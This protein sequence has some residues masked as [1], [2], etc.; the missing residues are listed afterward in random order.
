MT[1]PRVDRPNRKPQGD[2]VARTVR[3]PPQLWADLKAT[4]DGVR[5]CNINHSVVLAVYRLLIDQP[6]HALPR[7]NW[8]DSRN[9]LNHK[10]SKNSRSSVSTFVANEDAPRVEGSVLP[11]A[12]GESEPTREP[13][14]EIADLPKT[15]FKY[16]AALS[17]EE[18]R[19]NEM[20]SGRHGG[21]PPS[22]A[23][24]WKEDPV[25]M[26]AWKTYPKIGRRRSSSKLAW[27]EWRKL[28]VLDRMRVQRAIEVSIE[29]N[30]DWAKGYVPAYH[31]WLRT[32]SYLD[33][34]EEGREE[35]K[36]GPVEESDHDVF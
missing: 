36:A 22:G 26:K 15:G 30:F 3:F 6:W 8:H 11:V 12:V 24:P 25:F 5:L 17:W 34:A 1:Q 2:W 7:T 16:K 35:R 18:R 28:S 31:R 32:E 29:V 4:C 33:V 9:V 19:E 20:A 14:V 13:G 23:T 27:K 21:K 10:N